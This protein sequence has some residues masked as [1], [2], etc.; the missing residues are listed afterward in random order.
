MALR[1]LPSVDRVLSDP[2][3]SELST[4]LTHDALVQLA[5]Q[6]VSEARQ[7]IG[8]GAAAPSP[9][10]L[11]ARVLDLAED[12]LGPGPHAVINA[13]GVVLHTNLG[14]APLS[15]AARAAALAAS[16]GYVDLEFD[17]ATGERGSRLGRVEALLTRLTGAEAAFAVN[18]NAAAVL[19]ALTAVAAGRE[20]V[21]SRGQAVEI[22]GGF[23]IPDVL[24]QSGAR[25]VEVG[26]TNRTYLQDYETAITP[27]TAALLRVHPSNFQVIGF[28]AGVSLAELAGLGRERGLLV[29]D[30]LGSGCLLDTT[31][32]GLPAEPKAQDSV[33]AGADLVFFS[34]DKLMGG[35]QC[36]LIVGRREPVERLRRHPLA[37]ALRLDKGTIAALAATLV[38][39][40]RGEEL[41]TIPVW[42]MLST[43]LE[44]LE[45]RARAWVVALGEG[46]RVQRSESAI[47]GGSLPGATLPT[48]CLALGPFT[49]A[50]AGAAAFAGALRR[51]SPPVVGRIEQDTV[52]L[53]PRTVLPEEDEA[54][55]AACRAALA[56]V[57]PS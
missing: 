43:P 47:G 37:R 8:D 10:A 45:S 25:L 46:A 6:A 23:R 3:L 21:V 5:R 14:R 29:L 41:T 18:N 19:L 28:T 36:G 39:Y 48:W 11:A 7:R 33:A 54:M 13:T 30:D 31:P 32:F 9:T 40:L 57:L 26:T 53:D 4:R 24:A 27:Q 55:L 42:R 56:A 12:L 20:V 16:Q 50:G 34:G 44:T 38:H 52:L 1:S 2:A 17:L 51:A 15:D 35:P 49:D 22:G